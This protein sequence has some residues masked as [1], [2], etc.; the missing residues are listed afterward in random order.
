MPRLSTYFIRA[1][2]LHL[3]L[4]FTFGALMLW[5]KGLPFEGRL[6]L[7]LNPHIEMVLVGWTTQLVMGVGFWIVPR[8]TGENRY[9]RV[10]LAWA[11]FILI[12]AG[13]ITASVGLWGNA[14][15]L[16]LVGRALELSA[17]ISFAVH[18]WPRVKPFAETKGV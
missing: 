2:L 8:F 15:W 5:N 17:F 4:G 11:A 1:A 3:G 13:V 7:L 12:N 18:I 14:A 16:V 6:W 10:R 9:G